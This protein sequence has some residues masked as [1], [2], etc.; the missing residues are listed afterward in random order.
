[1][2]ATKILDGLFGSKVVAML[3]LGCGSFACGVL[4]VKLTAWWHRRQRDAT[5]ASQHREFGARAAT[6]S[7]FVSVLMCFGGGVLLYTGLIHL[8]TE[9]RDKFE[10]LQRMNALPAPLNDVHHLADLMFCFGFFSV[11]LIDKLVHW[12]LDW[13]AARGSPLHRMGSVAEESLRRSTSVRRRACVADNTDAAS[14]V[15]EELL[16]GTAP[17]RYRAVPWEALEAAEKKP[18][19]VPDHHRHQSPPPTDHHHQHHSHHHSVDLS[20]QSSSVRGLFAIL[21]LSF[22]E[23]FEGLAIG[24]EESESRVWALLVAVTSHKLL[25]AFCMGIDLAWSKTRLIMI[26]MYVGMFAIVSP[27]GIVIG[28]AI[29]RQGSSGT[30]IGFLTYVSVFLQAVAAGTLL[31]VVFLEVLPRHN[32]S[33]FLHYFAILA[34]FCLMFVFDSLSK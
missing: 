33:G 26:V 11:F 31:F 34:G 14:S 3:V 27:I 32:R 9:V 8:Q 28:E 6:E 22:H 10:K 5:H 24:L 4:P 30:E 13:T 19:H 1:M 18:A 12:F 21:A 20:S 15:K 25:I 7:S 2:D 16:N 17:E 29:H 23:V